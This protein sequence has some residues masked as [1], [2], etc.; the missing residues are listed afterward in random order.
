MSLEHI[1]EIRNQHC[2]IRASACKTNESSSAQTNSPFLL[3]DDHIHRLHQSLVEI[4]NVC[5]AHR[6]EQAVNTIDKDGR[7]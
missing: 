2:K 6:P 3:H 1:S 5:I 7:T 4:L